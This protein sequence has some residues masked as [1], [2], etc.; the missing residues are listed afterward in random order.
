MGVNRAVVPT[1]KEST[2]HTESSSTANVGKIIDF[3][4]LSCLTRETTNIARMMREWPV[5]GRGAGS[6]H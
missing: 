4:G 6:C 2:R 1:V 3:G 5:A